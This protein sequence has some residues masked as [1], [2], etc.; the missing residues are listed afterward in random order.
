MFGSAKKA[1]RESRCFS[2]GP[3]LHWRRMSLIETLPEGAKERWRTAS[4][5][6]DVLD[7][8][9]KA[10]RSPLVARVVSW[11]NLCRL[12]QDLEE[13]LLLAPTPAPEEVQLHR[14]L[15]SLAIGS[16][17]GLF[18]ECSEPRA[19]EPLGLT[20]ES[21]QAKL[22]SLRI[23]FEQWHTEIAPERQDMIL[24]EVFGGPS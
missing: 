11:F 14:A 24:K 19:L 5:L 3:L 6:A 1:G 8:Q 7:S 2:A 20:P 15:L 21:I 9:V 16:G 10:R 4:R 12:C 22:E 23:T 13:Q 17:E 18:L